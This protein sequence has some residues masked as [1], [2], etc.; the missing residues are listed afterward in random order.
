MIEHFLIYFFLFLCFPLQIFT[1][2]VSKKRIPARRVDDDSQQRSP[3]TINEQPDDSSSKITSP[4]FSGSKLW[5]F[6]SSILRFASL[7]SQNNLSLQETTAKDNE[8]HVVIRR[9]ASF[10]GRFNIYTSIFCFIKYLN[11]FPSVVC[12]LARFRK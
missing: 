8:S 11:K 3:D 6:V 9:C 2:K 1:P 10:T 4:K 12:S 7:N 5:S